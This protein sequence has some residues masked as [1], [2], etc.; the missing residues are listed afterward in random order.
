M[1]RKF[2][3]DSYPKPKSIDWLTSV[4]SKS[5]TRAFDARSI[6]YF[7]SSRASPSIQPYSIPSSLALRFRS[8]NKRKLCQ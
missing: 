3:P 7:L 8:K 2:H 6:D 5:S 4:N 1:A